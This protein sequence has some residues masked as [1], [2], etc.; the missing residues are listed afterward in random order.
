MWWVQPE[1]VVSPD[2]SWHA[3]VQLDRSAQEDIGAKFWVTAI[4]ISDTLS[5]GQINYPSEAKFSTKPI[6]LM[7]KYSDTNNLDPTTDNSD[8]TQVIV[9]IIGTIGLIVVA[10]I[11]LIGRAKS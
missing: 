11:S 10:F 6:Q 7:R 2:G 8:Y 5:V 1:A 3:N 4:V 9:A